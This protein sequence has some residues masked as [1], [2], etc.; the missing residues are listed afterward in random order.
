MNAPARLFPFRVAQGILA[1]APGRIEITATE[2]IPAP[3]DITAGR[4]LRRPVRPGRQR[5]A[6]YVQDALPTDLYAY[7]TSGG[8]FRRIKRQRLLKRSLDCLTTLNTP[9]V[10]HV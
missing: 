4:D 5:T 8:I 2:Y 9:E 7:G 3:F 10:C 1:R 6:T